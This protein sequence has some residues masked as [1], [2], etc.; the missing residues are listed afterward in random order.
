MR[1]LLSFL[2]NAFPLWIIVCST[3]ALIY[4]PSF[5]WFAGDM[6]TY[7]LGIIMLGMGLTLQPADFRVIVRSPRWLI[8][9]AILQFTIMPALGYALGHLFQLPVPYAIGLIVV[10]CCPGG[11]ASNVI[12][13]LAKANV[14]LSVAMTALSTLLAIALTP[15]L[16]TWLIGDRV[17][18]SAFQLFLGTVKVVLLP[19]T[20]GVLLNR[21]LPKLTRK[22]LPVAPLVAVVAIVLIVASIIGQ[23]KD[24]IM[25]SG[26]KLLMC[27]IILHAAGFALGYTLSFLLFRNKSVSRTIAIE[28]GMQNSGLGAYLSKANFANPAVAI[29]SALSSAI[30]SLIGSLMAAIWRKT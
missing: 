7:G 23:G 19:V 14:A 4:P 24:Q 28:T 27:I 5:T 15:L 10:S 3:A 2:V 29:P 6:I 20:M 30:H 8:V 21:Y 16:T 22:I 17:E 18:V 13:F 1:S 11:T 9:A 12:A 25:A 26:L